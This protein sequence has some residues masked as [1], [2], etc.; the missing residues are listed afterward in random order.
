MCAFKKTRCCCLQL[1]SELRDKERKEERKTFLWVLESRLLF[2]FFFFFFFFS[3]S[4][5]L[6]FP[7]RKLA[8]SSLHCFFIASRLLSFLSFNHEQGNDNLKRPPPPSNEWGGSCLPLPQ[9]ICYYVSDNIP[10][11]MSS[12]SLLLL[13]SRRKK[14]MKL[15]H[16]FYFVYLFSMG[17]GVNLSRSAAS[18]GYECLLIVSAFSP[19]F[20]VRGVRCL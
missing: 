18:P 4:F 2:F 14:W 11:K 8:R 6:F 7:T 20:L 3:L 1:G 16:Y 15:L 10:T 12:S 19:F 5:F 17:G 9:N 13:N